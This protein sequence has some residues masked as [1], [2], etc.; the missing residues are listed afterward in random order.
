[1]RGAPPYQWLTGQIR[2]RLNANGEL[3]LQVEEKTVDTSAAWRDA[4][5]ED[6]TVKNSMSEVVT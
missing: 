3:V 1:M 4:R 2:H 5:L 6:L